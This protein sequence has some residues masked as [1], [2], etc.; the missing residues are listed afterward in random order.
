MKDNYAVTTF[1][2][3]GWQRYGKQFVDTFLQNWPLPLFVFGEGQS[4][5]REYRNRR[6]LIWYDLRDDPE[7]EQFVAKFSG[8][9][10]NHPVDFNMM[11]VRF[12]H[13]V[14]AI[15][16]PKLPG[17]G[18][19]TWIDA[20]CWTT[21]MVE[22]F[23]LANL[24]PDNKA[25]TFLGRKGFMRPGQKAYTECGFVGYNQ[26]FEE[27]I[28]VLAKMRALYT[29]GRLFTLGQHNWHDSYAFDHARQSVPE[30]LLNNLSAH[31]PAGEL[32]VWPK[33]VLGNFMIHNKGPGRKA[34]AYGC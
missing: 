3:D 7:H 21:K 29:S 23:W 14:F 19:R 22:P 13:K 1:S 28:W 32:H 26:S 11:S 8:A 15:T 6:E 12:C 27:S 4:C 31:C 24:F 20:D 33:T 18:W 5:P 2:L 17:E 16:S 9:E 25:L 34:K 10:F 30:P